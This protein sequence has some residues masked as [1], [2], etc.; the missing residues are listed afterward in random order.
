MATPLSLMEQLLN[1][2]RFVLD[3]IVFPIAGYYYD[4][5]NNNPE[6]V[7][8]KNFTDSDTGLRV[9][10]IETRHD[11][12]LSVNPITIFPTIAQIVADQLRVSLPS[13]ADFRTTYTIF[14][15]ANAQLVDLSDYEK[16]IVRFTSQP[17]SAVTIAYMA[18][19]IDFKLTPPED[20]GK[21]KLPCVAFDYDTQSGSPAEIGSLGEF[22]ND[23][24]MYDIYG[25]NDTEVIRIGN[26]IRQALRGSIPII[27][28]TQS[29]FPLEKNGLGLEP[30]AIFTPG[31]YVDRIAKIE[32]VSFSKIQLSGTLA[33]RHHSTGR[34]IFT[35]LG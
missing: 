5:P 10:Y 22:V 25:R 35:H 11:N 18:K 20:P 28:F 33:D 29:G 3:D 17:Q 34:I 12:W 4:I 24:I 2:L 27:D 1:S 23:Y 19:V 31:G 14:N 16:G 8:L 30:R 9:Y 32:N 15:T 26:I 13:Q 7:I 6:A 21:I